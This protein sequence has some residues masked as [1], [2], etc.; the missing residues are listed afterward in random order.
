MHAKGHASR[1]WGRYIGDHPVRVSTKT[2]IRLDP[3][4]APAR[5]TERDP[6]A[7]Y[8][9]GADWWLARSE[10][11]V[12]KLE[13]LFKQEE[14]GCCL[15]ERTGAIIDMGQRDGR[16]YRIA[17]QL[18]RLGGVKDFDIDLCLSEIGIIIEEKWDGQR[19]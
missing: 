18:I 2:T 13:Y 19:A 14:V 16:Y 15:Y 3:N 12:R 6:M 9:E 1:G 7:D 10:H 17:I 11:S 8:I 5:K 4:P